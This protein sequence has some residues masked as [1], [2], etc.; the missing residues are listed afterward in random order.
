MR[1]LPQR[2]F[3]ATR[4]AAVDSIRESGLVG[5]PYV[6]ACE[7]ASDALGFIAFRLAVAMTGRITEREVPATGEVLEDYR[8]Q[9]AER[10]TVRVDE[11]DRVWVAVPE[12]EHNTHAAILTIDTSLTYPDQWA[13][14]T[15]HMALFFGDAVSWAYTGDI[16]AEAITAVDLVPLAARSEA[17]S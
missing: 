2:L 11:D 5:T 17:P 1:P 8:R 13:L 15:D 9:A 4:P 7:N 12:I 16:P 10:S 14:S 3:H 6:F